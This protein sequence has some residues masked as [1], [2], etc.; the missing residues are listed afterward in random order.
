M[1]ERIY[2]KRG[3]HAGQQILEAFAGDRGR[4]NLVGVFAVGFL[5]RCQFFRE[6]RSVLFR[7]CRRGRS[8]T[9]RSVENFHDVGILARRD[10]DS[11]YR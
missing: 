6:S 4:E 2:R 1:H 3:I 10:A 11:R 8:C 7:T 5:Q 9:P